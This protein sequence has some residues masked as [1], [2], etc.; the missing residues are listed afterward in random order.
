MAKPSNSAPFNT[1]SEWK[2]GNDVLILALK[3]ASDAVMLIKN[4]S[5]ERDQAEAGLAFLSKAWLDHQKLGLRLAD[6][7]IAKTDIAKTLK[8]KV[9]EI[10]ESLTR[11][12]KLTKKIDD[13]NAVL[14]TL[15]DVIK[16][17][18]GLPGLFAKFAL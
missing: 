11:L 13:I 15:T 14:A 17:V 10:S 7:E 5:A 18:S 4:P 1:L 12:T 3:V 6:A 8:A 16:A 9:A 2:V